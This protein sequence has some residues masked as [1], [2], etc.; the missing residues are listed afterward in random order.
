MILAFFGFCILTVL[1]LLSL[2]FDRAKRRSLPRCQRALL[3]IAHP[4][5]ET[6]FF[7][8]TLHGLRLSG[9]N[10]YMLCISTGNSNGLGVKRKYE[11]ASA[12]I[13]HG[14][15]LDNLTILNYDNFQDGFIQWSK[16][17]LAKVILR[18]MQMLDVDLVITF[19]EGGV[20]AHPNHIGCFRAL[21]YL[22][23]NGLIPAGVQIF[24]LESVSFWRKY[25]I[26]LDALI[27]SFHSTFLYISSPLLY[28]TAWRAMWAHRSQLV[29]FRCLYMLFSRYV[30]INTLKRIHAQPR[31]PVL[32]KKSHLHC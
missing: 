20:S 8:P 31:Y 21:Q 23:T 15:S 32:K 25:V 18:H 16:E 28:I 12:F 7:T 27:S 30:L 2:L 13:V 10:I 9:S 6:M 19:D 24:V 1:L 4:D 26:L 14:L 22:Y 5:D 3:V 17:E 11:L 29:W